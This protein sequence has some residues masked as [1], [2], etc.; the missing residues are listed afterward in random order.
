MVDAA[1]GVAVLDRSPGTSPAGVLGIEAAARI[2]IEFVRVPD[3]Q[4]G[5]LASGW[6]TM[7]IA[8]SIPMV[9]GGI[10]LLAYAYASG[11]PSGN[12]R[13]AAGAK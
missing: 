9:V 4:L 11:Q 1:I 12:Y 6:L 8:L 13:T 10:G 2:L 5:Y 3:A 7:G